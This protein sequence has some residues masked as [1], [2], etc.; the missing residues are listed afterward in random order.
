MIRAP[1]AAGVLQQRMVG[2][3]LDDHD[4]ARPP[5]LGQLPQEGDGHRVQADEHGGVP[6]EPGPQPADGLPPQHGRGGQGADQ[7][8]RQA[9]GAGQLQGQRRL[10]RADRGPLGG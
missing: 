7:R 8:G 2:V 3:G 6:D 1:V 9:D 5:G 4:A 10:A